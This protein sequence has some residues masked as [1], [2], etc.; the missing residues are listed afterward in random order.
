MA[1]GE[2]KAESLGRQAYLALRR[3]IRS[4]VIRADRRYSE[5]ELADL[6]G[7]SRTPVREALKALERDGALEPATRKGYQLR[8]FDEDEVGELVLLRKLLERL[9]VS[10]VA[11]QARPE[12]VAE[13]ERAVERQAEHTDEPEQMVALDEDFHLLIADLA[14]LT[15]TRETLAGLRS[16]MAIILAGT[17]GSRTLSDEVVAEHRKLVAAIAAGDADGAATIV[18]EHIEHA[19][20]PLLE[21]TRERRARTDALR[22]TTA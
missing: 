17:A 6:L 11:R 22:L 14:N 5:S 18:E 20:R 13:L 15:R 10:T 2:P 8:T 3:A 4:G 19:T 7:V 12:D 1:P 16:A 9:T 21:A